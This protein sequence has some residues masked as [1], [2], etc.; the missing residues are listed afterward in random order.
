MFAYATVEDIRPLVKGGLNQT[1]E[2][3]LEKKLF[4]LSAKLTG[5][6]P[7]LRTIWEEADDDSDLKNFVT[8]M[9][10]EA[11]RA[12][13]VNPEGMASETIGVFAYSRFDQ[14]DDGP[15]S[16]DDLAALRAMLEEEMEEQ[17]GSFKMNV[18]HNAYP[19]APMPTPVSYSNTRTIRSWT[20]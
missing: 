10:I 16:K 3:M 12:F 8:A 1:K 7:G 11:G 19:A 14:K 13:I 4:M 17:V 20:R 5:M 6:F 9:V 18:G 2:A 15:F